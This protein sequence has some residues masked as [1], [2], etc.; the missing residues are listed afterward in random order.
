M[1]KARAGGT[2]WVTGVS[3]RDKF[4]GGAEKITD[5][6]RSCRMIPGVW[7][8]MESIGANSRHYRGD[9]EHLLLKDGVPLTVGNAA[10]RI[11]KMNG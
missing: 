6:I 1:E 11:W 9:K 8:E 7:F 5:Y 3:M 2:V 10:S 4:P